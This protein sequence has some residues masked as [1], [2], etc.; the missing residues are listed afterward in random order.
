VGRTL[1]LITGSHV[2]LTWRQRGTPRDPPPPGGRP[3]DARAL[4]VVPGPRPYSLISIVP[5]A[6][7]CIGIATDNVSQPADNVGQYDRPL[8]PTLGY[9]PPRVHGSIPRRQ[10]RQ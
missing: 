1:G 3:H 7:A 8:P 2:V 9:N 5:R 6:R 10:K 4:R